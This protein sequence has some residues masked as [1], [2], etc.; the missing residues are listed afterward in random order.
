MATDGDL[1]THKYGIFVYSM[2]THNN[3]Y[4]DA[5]NG[6]IRLKSAMDYESDPTYTLIIYATDR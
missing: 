4:L 3:F 5:N 6:E 1:S 2:T